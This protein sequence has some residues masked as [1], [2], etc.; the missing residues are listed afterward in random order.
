MSRRFLLRSLAFLLAALLLALAGG[1]WY[2]RTSLPKISGT[3]KVAGLRAPVEVVRDRHGI[4]HIRATSWED[5]NFALGYAHAQDRL[6]QMEM[7]RHIAAGRLSEI[8]GDST[9]NSDRFMRTLGVYRLAREN[10]ATLD[11]PTRAI[12][13][14]YADGVNAFLQSREG[15]LPPEFL[16]LGQ[17]P[18]PW[19]IADSLA[20]IKMMAWDLS[21]SWRSELTRLRLSARLTPQQMAEFL[22]PYPGDAPHLLPDLKPLYAGFADAAARLAE[23]APQEPEW[24]IGSNNWVID[25]RRSASGKPLLANDPHLGL[26][27]P[28]VWYFAHLQAGEQPLIGATLPGVPMVVLGR[29]DRLA[30][31]FTNTGPDVQDLFIEK[32]SDAE[33]Q[34]YRTPSGIAPFVFYPERIRVKGKP[35]LEIKVRWSRHGPVISDVLA[36]AAKLLPKDAVLAFAWTALRADDKSPQALVNLGRARSSVEFRT[37]LRDF[38][39]PQQNVVY[40]D[41]EGNI[42]F[43]APGLVPIRRA[44]NPLQG[45]APSP[46][47]DARF[48]W[49][50]FI[51]FEQLPQRVNP[52]GGMFATANDKIV[53]PNYPHWIGTEWAPPFRVDRIREMLDGKA[54]HDFASFA[55]M[56][57]D[58]RSRYLAEVLPLIWDAPASGVEEAEAIQA[59]KKWNFEMTAERSE[60]L[61]A[62]AW[63][64]ELGRLIYQDELGEYF[65]NLWGER[66]LFM[67]NV[68]RDVQGQARWCDDQRTPEVETC[69]QMASKALSLA[70]ADLR[71]RYGDDH[72]RWRWSGAHIAISEHRPFSRQP[73]L[74][75]LFEI[76]TPVPGDTWTVNVGRISITDAARP[77][78][79]RHGPSLRAIYDLADLENSRF[80]HSSGQSGNPFSPFYR[81]LNPLWAG[82]QYLPMSTRP[83]SYGENAAGR[84]LLM[85]S[86]T[87]GSANS[88]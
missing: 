8:F 62:T 51:P 33:G 14:A 60:P 39:V 20:W 10:A 12:F 16:L 68:L 67:I 57:A 61:I 27:A 37:S 52:A 15:A 69:A 41:V 19:Q 82:V 81:D 50:G 24:A 38:M 34:T 80:V 78:A 43:I 2:A 29:N 59:L 3:V 79:T 7:S 4:P 83:E 71:V 6:W 65:A 25:G 30:W 42:G 47:W 77:F 70:L 22:A 45:L 18:E 75:R 35:D 44:D 23:L 56:Q 72:A 28:A 31:G 63:L 17:S 1:Y 58:V 73:W 66:P 84:L 64:R 49:Q 21:Q 36:D 76:A 53:E 85:P 55:R 86:V 26:T 87:P 9:V 54:R 74:A 88:G 40:A 5:A 48:D 46:G 11:E 32:V 13:Q